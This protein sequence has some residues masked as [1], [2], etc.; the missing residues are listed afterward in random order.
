M[1]ANLSE[2]ELKDLYG[3]LSLDSREDV[4][5]AAL[6]YLLGV[7]GSVDGMKF[8]ENNLD[9]VGKVA[10]LTID[11]SPGV[12]RNACV[13]LLNA[14][15][16]QIVARKLENNDTFESILPRIVDKNCTFADNAAMLLSNLTRSEQGC[17]L[18]LRIIE[19]S[20]QYSLKNIFEVLCNEKYNE[21]VQL[22]HVA[23]FLSNLSRL[24]AVRML[25]LDKAVGLMQKLLPYVGF[26]KS[27]MCRKGVVGIIRNC[28][29]E[30]GM[31]NHIKLFL[32]G[33]GV[34]PTKFEPRISDI[35]HTTKGLICTHIQ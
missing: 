28:C 12:Q 31:Y 32:G 10:Q 8:I 7:T 15:T 22:H 1:A 25:A 11:I 27:L 23:I 4:K 3:I 14:S 16:S 26:Q 19:K 30:Y 24:K 2:N 13:F 5:F 20:Q 34:I 33:E 29:F 17:E 6:E 21:H 18:C 35:L 9:L